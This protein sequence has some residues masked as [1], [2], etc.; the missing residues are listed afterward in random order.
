MSPLL[1]N[2]KIRVAVVSTM[3]FG[4]LAVMAAPFV[5]PTQ[6]SSTDA[7]A[8]WL[9]DRLHVTPDD[10]FDAAVSAALATNPASFDE[11]VEAFVNEYSGADAFR[12]RL[13]RAFGYSDAAF[14]HFLALRVVLAPAITKSLRTKADVTF[15]ALDVLMRTRL[16]DGLGRVV[17]LPFR[18]APKPPAVLFGVNSALPNG[19]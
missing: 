18:E 19:P 15:S 2:N 1:R 6:G 12:V 3:L 4:M 10:D 11:F 5:R 13:A 14:R 7:A 17:M 8:R 16:G 9:L